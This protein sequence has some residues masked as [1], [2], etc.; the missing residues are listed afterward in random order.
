MVDSALDFILHHN[1]G[2]GLG[3]AAVLVK[4]Y[5]DAA[6]NLPHISIIGTI[7]IGHALEEPAVFHGI[8]IAQYKHILRGG[9][10]VFLG[11]NVVVTKCRLFQSLP[12][13]GVHRVDRGGA[14]GK[15]LNLYRNRTGIIVCTG[16]DC[17]QPQF[18]VGGGIIILQIS[19]S[20]QRHYAVVGYRTT[21]VACAVID[22]VAAMADLRC[23]V[24]KNIVVIVGLTVQ[25]LPGAVNDSIAPNPD[26]TVIR[27]QG[28][29]FLYHQ[30]SIISHGVNS[31]A[32]IVGNI[33]L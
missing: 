27:G 10:G 8:G 18:A 13:S 1:A 9:I 15:A 11:K 26:L 6:G 30:A 16:R 33:D 32:G 19:R 14:G 22:Q 25:L 21:Q 4:N 24:D 5:A 2:R 31:Y 12:V 28:A 17:R 20:H 3:I 23:A 7:G 29:A